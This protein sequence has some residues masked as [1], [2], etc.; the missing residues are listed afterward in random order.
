MKRIFWVVVAA[1]TLAACD[2]FT[3]APYGISPDNNLAL[4]TA[5]GDQNVAVGPFTMQAQVDNSCRAA[6]PIRLPSDVTFEAYIQKAFTDELKLAGR[7]DPQSP[8]TLTGKV[9]E[10]SFSSTSGSWDI[11][12]TLDSSNGKTSSASEHYEFHTSYSAV[13]ACRNVADAFQPAVQ[14]LIAKVVAAPNFRVMA[15]K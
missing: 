5:L 13:S 1:L 14:A 12:L 3:A 4:K 8:V 6:G 9:T 7:Y 10:L 11:A 15:L 2:T